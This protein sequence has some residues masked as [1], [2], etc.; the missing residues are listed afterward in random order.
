MIL[1][2]L[3]ER[4]LKKSTIN[5]V[6]SAI[7][8]KQGKG[9]T[10]SAS[11]FVINR[12]LASNATIITNVKSFCLF[13]DTIY[14]PNINDLIDYVIYYSDSLPFDVQPNIIIFF[15]EIFTILSKNSKNMNEKTLSFLS[16]LR[17]RKIVFVTTAQEWREID[18]TFRRYVRFQ[19]D[20]NMISTPL[21]NTAFLIN[22]VNDGEQLHWD[23][24]ENDYIAPRLQTNIAKGN[25]YIIE[26]Y[27]TFETIQI[28]KQ[29]KGLKHYLALYPIENLNELE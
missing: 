25:L 9:K 14:I 18:V 20:C 6:A 11:R 12:K 21:T 4:D 1:N 5:L 22:E 23:N 3:F 24:N 17:K 16:Q 10:Y 19:I 26:S 13:S 28:D 7:V 8:G 2:P 15:D 27:D 29:P